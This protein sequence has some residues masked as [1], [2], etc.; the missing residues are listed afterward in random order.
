MGKSLI[1]KSIFHTLGAEVYYAN[2]IR[3]INL[4]TILDFSIDN[5]SYRICRL[6][7]QFVL[8]RNDTIVGKY[9]SVAELSEIISELLQL[10][11]ELV[12]KDEN[13]SKVSTSFL[14]VAILY[15]P[16]ERMVEQL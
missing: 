15:R 5:G 4:L 3:N 7:N 13:D 9:R 11:I 12:N 1:V 2:N 6:N 10:E 14:V 16:G 8:Y